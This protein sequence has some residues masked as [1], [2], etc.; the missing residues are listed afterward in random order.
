MS[1]LYIT[2]NGCVISVT[3]QRLEVKYKLGRE[4][5]IPIET[6]ESIEIFGKSQMTAQAMQVSMERLIP[7]SFHSRGGHYLGKLTPARNLNI[8]RQRL[9]FKMTEDENFSVQLAARIIKAKIHNQTV[10]LRRYSRN[11]SVNANDEIHVMLQIEQRIDRCRAVEELMGCEGYAARQYF[12]GLGNLV[13]NE[14]AFKRRSKRPPKDEFNAMLSLGY[15]MLFHEIYA[16][17]VTADI[18]G[19]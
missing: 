6:L 8:S 2:E 15:S 9:Q 13:R 4:R 1:F 3:S 16:K 17:I 5:S 10:L 12:K 11:R 19:F 18:T 7:V 14:F